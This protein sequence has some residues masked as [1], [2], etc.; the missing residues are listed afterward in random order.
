MPCGEKIVT[1][2]HCHQAIA[3]SAYLS[4]WQCKCGQWFDYTELIPFY[5]GTT[6]TDRNPKSCRHD[7]IEQDEELSTAIQMGFIK[8]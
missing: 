6:I 3:V 8:G 4:L 5:H 2:P 1:C 7:W